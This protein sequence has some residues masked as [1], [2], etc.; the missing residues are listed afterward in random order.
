MWH[1]RRDFAVQHIVFAGHALPDCERHSGPAAQAWFGGPGSGTGHAGH[2][3]P[4]PSANRF[5]TNYVFRGFPKAAAKLRFQAASITIS[6]QSCRALPSGPG[7][8]RSILEATPRS[9][10]TCMASYTAMITDQFR[11]SVGVITYHYPN[12]P[13]GVI[14]TG[15]KSGA[16]ST[17]GIAS[18]Q[19]IS[20]IPRIT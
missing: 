3:G 7:H 19:A 11:W 15:M 12:A 20:S 5:T 1:E 16:S 4:P 18:S 2:S 14:T 17:L 6:V 10:W 13:H 9:S 8:H